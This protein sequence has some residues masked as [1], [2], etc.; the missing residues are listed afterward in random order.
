MI[1]LRCL[2]PLDIEPVVKS[3][4]KTNRAVVVEEGN[5][6]VSAGIINERG[7]EWLVTGMGRL[8]TLEDIGETVV[9]ARAT[10]RI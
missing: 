1:D 4:K 9:T 10:I 5:E 6:N 7:A 2:R 3:V 8:R